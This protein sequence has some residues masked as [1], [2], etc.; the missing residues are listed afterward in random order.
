[1]ALQSPIARNRN[2]KVRSQ[3]KMKT[4]YKQRLL[5]ILAYWDVALLGCIQ[6]IQRH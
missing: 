3:F 5:H 2:N 1:M 4:E 6:R